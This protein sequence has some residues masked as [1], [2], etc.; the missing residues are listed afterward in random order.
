M[1][2]NESQNELLPHYLDGQVTTEERLRA[3]ESLR[4]DP[5]AREFLREIAEQSVMVADLQRTASAGS[6][7]RL[8]SPIRPVAPRSRLINAR[9]KRWAPSSI[10]RPPLPNLLFGSIRVRLASRGMSIARSSIRW[11][12]TRCTCP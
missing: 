5:T 6:V 7:D 2:S 11:P 8:L 1:N 9:T 4:N 10:C 12:V 3:L